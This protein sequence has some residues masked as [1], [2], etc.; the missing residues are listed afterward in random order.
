MSETRGEGRGGG[1]YHSLTTDNCVSLR[2]R[3]FVQ[4]AALHAG[5]DF[6]DRARVRAG[7]EASDELDVLEQMGTD[8]QGASAGSLAGKVVAGVLNDQS[9]VEIAGKVDGA[10][11]IPHALR[12]DDIDRVGTLGAVPRIGIARRYARQTGGQGGHDGGW[13]VIAEAGCQRGFEG[14]NIRISRIMGG[15]VSYCKSESPHV[16]TRLA[17]VAAL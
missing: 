11:Y 14:G 6:E 3:D 13:V 10:L 12:A 17:H 1:T 7:G 5:A 8:A 15:G 16:A 4:L 9:Q 2:L